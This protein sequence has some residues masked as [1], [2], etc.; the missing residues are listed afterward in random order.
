MR[1]YKDLLAIRAKQKD[2]FARSD[3]IEPTSPPSPAHEVEPLPQLHVDEIQVDTSDPST[4]LGSGAGDSSG[5]ERVFLT[6]LVLQAATATFIV[7][8][9]APSPWL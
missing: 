9:A 2:I 7:A 5:R 1:A 6:L 4:V 3:P 8:R